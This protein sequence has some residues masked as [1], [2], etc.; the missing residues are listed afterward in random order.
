MGFFNIITDIYHRNSQICSIVRV[1]TCRVLA[2]SRFRLSFTQTGHCQAGF[3]F[4][5]FTLKRYLIALLFTASITNASLAGEKINMQDEGDKYSYVQGFAIGQRI[6]PSLQKDKLKLKAFAIGIRDALTADS[7]LTKKQMSEVIAKGPVHLRAAREKKKLENEKFLAENK[8]REGVTTTKSGLQYKV[9]KS[10]PKDGK[11]PQGKD[12]VVVHYHGTL[13]NGKKFDSSYDR[14]KPATFGVGQVIP[15][16][17]E[18]LKLMKPGDKWA[19]V[20]PPH[21]GYGARGAGG[22]IGPNEVLLFDVELLEVKK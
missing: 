12:M 9:I 2:I 18:V 8:A 20:I 7:Q 11:S 17:T 14:G 16:W 6:R 15:G 3:Y 13:T 10:G 4:R 5:K 1:A 21:L 19:V 22:V